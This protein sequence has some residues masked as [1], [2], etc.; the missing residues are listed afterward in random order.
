[1]T[2]R[3]LAF[4]LELYNVKDTESDLVADGVT[5]AAQKHSGEQTQYEKTQEEQKVA[6]SYHILIADDVPVNLSV[7]K[8]LL[9]KIGLNDVETAVDG[10]DALEKLQ[11]SERPFDFVL[12]D[13]WMPHMDGTQLAEAM[14][15]DHRLARIPIVAVTADVD[16]GSTYDMTLFQRVLSKPVNGDKLRTLFGAL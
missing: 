14:N 12:T 7:L 4:T 3:S 16:V 2:N 1:M 5:A 11:T 8:A 9:K 6:K 13:V 10:Q 15:R